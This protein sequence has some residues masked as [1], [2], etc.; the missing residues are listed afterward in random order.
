MDAQELQSN[1]TFSDVGP[2]IAEIEVGGGREGGCFQSSIVL[3]CCTGLPFTPA[4][5]RWG[6]L[7]RNQQSRCGLDTVDRRVIRVVCKFLGAFD[8][9][10][11]R[12]MC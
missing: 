11:V 3:A 9:Q 4:L 12:C 1:T 6:K 2:Q 7:Q 5:L 10:L 8:G